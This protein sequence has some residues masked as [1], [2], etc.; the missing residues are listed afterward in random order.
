[1][2][3]PAAPKDRLIAGRGAKILKDGITCIAHLDKS[4]VQGLSPFSAASQDAHGHI[5]YASPPPTLQAEIL[6]RRQ[7][8]VLNST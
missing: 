1:M 3:P 8:P 4:L 5:D 2:D 6:P 7:R